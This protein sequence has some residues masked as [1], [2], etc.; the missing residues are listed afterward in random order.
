MARHIVVTGASS[1]IGASIATLLSTHSLADH[2]TLVGRSTSRLTATSSAVSSS[3]PTP[4]T[5]TLLATDLSS[6]DPYAA[7]DALLA[8]LPSSPPVTA[9]VHAAAISRDALLA[10]SPPSLLR[11]TLETNTGIALSLARSLS[12]SALRDRSDPPT[13]RDLVLIGSVVGG[14]LGSPGQV[15]YSASKAALRG[16]VSSLALE[17]APK[18]LRVN[19]IEPGFIDTPMTQGLSEKRKAQV[20]ADVPLGGMGSPDDVAEAVVFLL[21]SNYATGSIITLDGGLSL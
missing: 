5:T 20:E 21:K 17:M 16:I 6:P 15:P 13:R 4:P 18:N 11:Q 1:G 10:S 12:R 8:S 7:G 9:I 19:M 14:S 2:L 3:S